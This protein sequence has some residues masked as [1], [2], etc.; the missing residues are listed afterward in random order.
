MPDDG[1]PPPKKKPT[2]IEDIPL[3]IPLK[4]T[5]FMSVEAAATYAIARVRSINN[6]SGD[7]C[8]TSAYRTLKDEG[9]V[10]KSESFHDS[11]FL[12]ISSKVSLKVRHED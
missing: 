10:P 5:E 1:V 3:P 6:G 4:G 9:L 11:V 12:L 7:I 8:L 2:K